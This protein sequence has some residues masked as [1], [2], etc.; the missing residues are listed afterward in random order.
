MSGLRFSL[1]QLRPEMRAQVQAKLDRASDSGL[2]RTI[3]A[4]QETRKS[5]HHNV[6]VVVDDDKFDS[7]LEERHYRLL[8]ARQACGQ[9]RALRRQVR[10]SLFM[11]HGEHLGTYRADFTFEELQGGKKWA[12][13]VAD[14]KSKWTRALPGWGKIKA[15]MLNCHGHSVLELL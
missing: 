9:I 14:A 8:Q 1:D 6:K 10:F 2:V 3:V 13:V 11:D 4:G 7:K 5:K 15:L 12:Y